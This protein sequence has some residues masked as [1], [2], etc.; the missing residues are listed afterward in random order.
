MIS[1]HYFTIVVIFSGIIYSEK[2]GDSRGYSAHLNLCSNAV[3]PLG[4]LFPLVVLPGRWYLQLF[5]HFRGLFFLGKKVRGDVFSSAGDLTSVS[6][7]YLLTA[8]YKCCW[9]FGE[10]YFPLLIFHQSLA[11]SLTPVQP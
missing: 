10:N 5:F 11:S 2:N 6:G 9:D 8:Y 3:L 1:L 4:F 7:L